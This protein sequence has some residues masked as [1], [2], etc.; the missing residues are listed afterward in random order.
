MHS[1]IQLP[2]SSICKD[3][4][5][6]ECFIIY[7]KKALGKIIFF[8]NLCTSQENGLV[9]FVDFQQMTQNQG[10]HYESTRFRYQL[11]TTRPFYLK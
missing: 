3:F 10:R 4:L 11:M 9:K 5:V 1:T 2:S 6:E 8:Y 7:G